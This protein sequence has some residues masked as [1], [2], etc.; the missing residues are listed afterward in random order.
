MDFQESSCSRMKFPVRG[1]KR[2]C[3]FGLLNVGDH[4]FDD[5]FFQD[6]GNKA[7]I[8]DWSVVVLNSFHSLQGN[9]FF[10]KGE[11]WAVLKD[12]GKHPSESE[13]LTIYVTG[14]T[15]I[16]M[17]VFRRAVGIGYRDVM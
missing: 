7:E 4:T 3:S 9:F 15:R 12:V 13:K 2:V 6:F 10:N 1:L 5:H 16:S 14:V 8:G 17:Q 11:T